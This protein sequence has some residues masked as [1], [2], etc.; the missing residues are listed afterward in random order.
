[1]DILLIVKIF[2]GPDYWGIINPKWSHC[3]KGRKQS[4]IDINPDSLL[5][6]PGLEPIQMNKIKDTV[7]IVVNSD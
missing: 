7:S 4:P 3:S 2:K 6:D 5:F 1:M